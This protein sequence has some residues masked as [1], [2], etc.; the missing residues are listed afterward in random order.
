[1]ARRRIAN[2]PTDVAQLAAVTR[3]GCSAE[4]AARTLQNRGVAISSRTVSRRRKEAADAAR[5]QRRAPSPPPPPRG[6]ADVLAKLPEADRALVI[7]W[8]GDVAQEAVDAHGAAVLSRLRALGREQATRPPCK[9]CG[10]RGL[11]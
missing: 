7:D 9:T 3:S 1:M 4:D 10:L 5:A 8:A 6:A 2:R 11:P